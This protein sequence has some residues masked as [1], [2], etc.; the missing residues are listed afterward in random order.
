M[1]IVTIVTELSF[2]LDTV[3]TRTISQIDHD[4]EKLNF[5][6]ASLVGAPISGTASLYALG[7]R[8]TLGVLGTAVGFDIAGQTAQGGEYRPG[9]TV[10]AAQTA[11]ALGPLASSS[12]GYNAALGAVAGGSNVA[13]NNFYYDENKSVQQGALLGGVAGGAGTYFGGIVS[14]SLKNMPSQMSIPYFQTPATVTV[15]VPAATTV[16]KN[17]ETIFQNIPAFISLPEVGND[18]NL[19]GGGK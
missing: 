2:N 6:M 3:D 17:V 19:Q 1:V 18:D 9:Q 11:L 15:P 13:T 10:L 8:G 12:W 7:G 14:D 5:G 16:G 4:L